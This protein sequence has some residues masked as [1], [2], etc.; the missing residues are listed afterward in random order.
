MKAENPTPLHR[1]D[2][3]RIA[4][5]C[6]LLISWFSFAAATHYHPISASGSEGHCE[7]C[8]VMH[9]GS[10]AVPAAAVPVVIPSTVVTQMLDAEQRQVKNLLADFDLYSRPPPLV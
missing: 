10:D 8:L 4:V 3:R 6:L 9:G 5:F 7:F 2:I 1:A